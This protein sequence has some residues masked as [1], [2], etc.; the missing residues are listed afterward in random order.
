MTITDPATDSGL[1]I[2]SDVEINDLP[3]PE[4]LVE[5]LLP[6]DSVA[7]LYGPPEA[8]KSFVGL[9][10]AL[11]IGT[12]LPFHGLEVAQGNVVYVYAEGGADLKLRVQAWKREHGFALDQPCG[13]WFVTT[14]VDLT[15]EKG[16]GLQALFDAITRAEVPGPIQL[17][18][19]DTLARCFG[20][21]DENN[22]RDMNTFNNRCHDA[23][24]AYECAVLII[25]HTGW[26]ENRERG[27]RALEGSI[28]TKIRCKKK[29]GS[30]AVTLLC[31]KQ[32]DALYFEP[33]HL[34]LIE[35]DLGNEM[36]SCVLRDADGVMSPQRA[37]HPD[38]EG[39]LVSL[40]TLGE[41][42][43]TYTEWKEEAAKKSISGS[44]FKRTRKELV[45]SGYVHG[46]PAD[47]S[48]GFK[49]TL[50]NEG[51]RALGHPE[52]V[53][54]SVNPSTSTD[55][56][57]DPMGSNRVHPQ[58]VD[59]TPDTNGARTGSNRSMSPNARM[60]SRGGAYRAPLEPNQKACIWCGEDHSPGGYCEI[61]EALAS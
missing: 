12:G 4:W 22:T 44:S 40:A 52:R 29:K 35:I 8:G 16:A 15:D 43:A 28:R 42:G 18:V 36:T 49:Y 30:P 11:C 33:I 27:N 48:K 55:G 10:L 45:V 34:Q 20:A 61:R 25:H 32:N 31:E 13:V 57:E 5:K 51:K 17:L 2:Y 26:D 38:A 53:Q 39:M 23:R 58:A 14:S 56:A 59:Q 3:D 21:K 54:G 47:E 6:R 19:F 37:L 9:D 7:A 1:P 24:E 41:A 50:T 60:G 46:P